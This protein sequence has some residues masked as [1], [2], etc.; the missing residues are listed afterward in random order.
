LSEFLF[1]KET[2]AY[3]IVSVMLTTVGMMLNHD[4]LDECSWQR[5]LFKS[6]YIGIAWGLVAYGGFFVLIKYGKEPDGIEFYFI[7]VF[8]ALT[9]PY[10]LARLK[11][12][13][14]GWLT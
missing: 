11:N 5:E 8:G 7:F 9:S 2:L 14:K 13:V 3:L 12:R 4:G 10:I 6:I 1:S